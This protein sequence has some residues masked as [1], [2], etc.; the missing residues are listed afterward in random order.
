MA[1]ACAGLIRGD[2]KAGAIKGSA[3]TRTPLHDL[4]IS[5][6][7]TSWIVHSLTA[8]GVAEAEPRNEKHAD[9]ERRNTFIHNT[10]TCMNESSKQ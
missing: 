5:G 2:T 7:N 8:W 10:P 4:A 1:G 6:K 9:G 3:A